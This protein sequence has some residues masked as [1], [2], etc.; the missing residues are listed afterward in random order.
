MGASWTKKLSRVKLKYG[1]ME[2]RGNH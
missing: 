2:A 1:I